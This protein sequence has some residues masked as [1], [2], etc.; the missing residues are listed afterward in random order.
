MNIWNINYIIGVTLILWMS[1]GFGWGITIIV[2]KGYLWI[3]CCPLFH[4]YIVIFF[5]YKIWIFYVFFS[6]PVFYPVFCRFQSGSHFGL[7]QFDDRSGS[8]N[9]GLY[10][11][12]FV[13]FSSPRG[14]PRINM[15]VLFCS[16]VLVFLSEILLFWYNNF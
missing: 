2:L 11:G 14:F 7:H 16:T 12:I 10:R 15:C 1:L 9:I 13:G 8:D 5:F 4:C 6:Q 3:G